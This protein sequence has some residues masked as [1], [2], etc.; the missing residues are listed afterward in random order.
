MLAE[1]F[2]TV[3]GL[4]G[5]FRSEHAGK[6]QAEYNDFIDWLISSNH[7]ELV[8]LLEL[9]ANAAISIKIMLKQDRD[10]FKAQLE[11]IDSALSAFASTIEGFGELA[12][13]LHPESVISE[14]ALSILHQF[15]ESG[16][17][18]L[19][20]VGTS[21]GTIYMFLE[22]SGSLDIP[23]SRFAEDDFAVLVELGLLRQDYNSQG[24]TLY[25]FTRAA[26]QLVSNQNS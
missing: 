24:N 2:A 7:K 11:K 21:G 18:K 20:E 6:S 17:S 23:E 4:I 13:S 5:Q 1:S 15:N 12:K 25:I 16:S 8:S 14:Q 10:H 22:T 26:H 3:V 19:L 9:N